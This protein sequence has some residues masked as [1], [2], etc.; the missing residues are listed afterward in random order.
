MA[1]VSAGLL[2]YRVRAGALEVLLAHPG[3]PFFRNKDE[4]AWTLPKGEVE[5]GEEPLACARREFQEETGIVA[6]PPFVSLG[7]VRQKA[8]KRVFAWAFQGEYDAVEPPPSN[9]FE[10]EWPPK[11]GKRVKFPEIDRLAFFGIEAAK[12][13]I[14]QAQTALI[15]RLAAS[16]A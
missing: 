10:L 13:K 11:S 16:L 12:G 15:E 4:G 8:G 1:K 3:G 2:M 14:N 7:E 6:E 9:T 5:E